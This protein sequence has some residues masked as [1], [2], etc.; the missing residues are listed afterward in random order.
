MPETEAALGARAVA[1]RRE[2]LSTLAVAIIVGVILG[3]LT[4]RAAHLGVAANEA[5]ATSTGP[6]AIVAAVIGR[7]A[8]RIAVAVGASTLCLWLATLVFYRL[9]GPVGGRG[10]PAFWLA[11]IVTVGP[12]LGALGHLSRSR[13][14]AGSVAIAV[15]AG[16]LLG[17]SARTL[18]AYGDASR[19]VAVIVDAAAAACWVLSA[20]GPRWVI[21][22]SL[23]PAA[24]VAILL[25]SAVEV[26]SKTT[27]Y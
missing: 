4:Q 3:A 6:W 20:R 15:V 22:A 9:G 25:M 10:T 19:W 18:L 11:A 8:T 13:S 12:A 27:L 16:W 17:E 24:A 23:V 5:L 21:A 26:V 1:L 7:R 2:M 14:A